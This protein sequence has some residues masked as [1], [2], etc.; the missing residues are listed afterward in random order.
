MNHLKK[1]NEEFT[2]Q[3]Q[4]FDRYAPKADEKVESRFRDALGSTAN[5]VLLDLACGPGVV[6]AAVAAGARQV[7]GFDAT[8]A[9]LDKARKRCAEAGLTNVDFRHGGAE[10]LPFADGTFDGVV[11]RLAI[12]HFV[13]PLRVLK[14]V[15][16]VTRSGGRLV[17]VD[18]IVSEDRDEA[19]LQNAIEN[20]RD[21][22]HVRML[23][24]TELDAVITQ[25][26]FTIADISTWN[27]SREFEEWMG[28]ANDDMRTQSLRVVARALAEEGRSAGMGLAV[29]EG[30]T[31]F[32]HRWRLVTA[33]KP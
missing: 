9:M 2:R 25:A 30:K 8:P 15:F 14:E 32:F 4:T 16:R 10:S 23:P 20:L 13:D 28:I 24:A 12:H 17:V 29:R 11:T 21:P 7:T 22:S 6:T 27:K 26:G 33:R 1:I 5:G 31:V 3:A 19:A 18:V